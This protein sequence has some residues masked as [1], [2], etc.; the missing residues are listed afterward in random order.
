MFAG[1]EREDVGGEMQV[2]EVEKQQRQALPGYPLAQTPLASL[3]LQVSSGFFRKGH[4]FI[5]VHQGST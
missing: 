2:I 3:E 5:L 1:V 4:I